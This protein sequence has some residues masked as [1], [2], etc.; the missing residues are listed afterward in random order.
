MVVLPQMPKLTFSL[1]DQTV[2]ALRKAAERTRKPQS[3]IVREAI[4]EYT[5]REERLSDSERARLIG[6][7]RRIGTRPAT[8]S[9]A[10]VDRE[11]QE[12]RRSRRT[13]WNR[14]AR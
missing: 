13:G 6:V 8:R 11:L 2:E 9:Q 14:A 5:S 12:I 3:L 7:L 1:D 4:A 10:D